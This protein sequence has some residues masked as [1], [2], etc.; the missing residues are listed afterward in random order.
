MLFIGTFL[1]YFL[2]AFIAFKL[3]VK[4][5]RNPILW[6]LICSFPFSFVGLIVYFFTGF[7]K[8]PTVSEYL[9][10]HPQC[11]TGRGISCFRC[12]SSSIR[13]WRS[14]SFLSVSQHHICNHCGTTLYKS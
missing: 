1:V 7:K 4:H 6:C 3:A 9:Q 8:L 11:S 2:P 10:A 12:R 14:E 13:L 5:G